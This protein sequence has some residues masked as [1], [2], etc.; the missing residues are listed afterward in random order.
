MYF[1]EKR[2]SDLGTGTK[3][4]LLFMFF[5]VAAGTIYSIQLTWRILSQEKLMMD[6]RVFDFVRATSGEGQEWFFQSISKLGSVVV[7][8]TASVLIL[9]YFLFLSSHS[10]WLGLYFALGMA[11]V[12]LITKLAKMST[13][14]DRPEFMGDYHGS[15]S[16]FPSGHTSGAV[17]FYGFMMYVIGASKL[18]R[19]WK[20][21]IHL[22][23]TFIIVGI[24]MSRV[25]LGV[26]Y[27]SDLVTGF[28][29]GC[30]WLALC[31]TGFEMT[32]RY[33]VKRKRAEEDEE[34]QALGN[35]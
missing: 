8:A 30:V 9:L 22:L 11:G 27:F 34:S 25:Y 10:K 31:I 18:G 14:R 16:S 15:T 1:S 32:M 24:S 26:H 13:S 17:V 12:S 33:R 20:A 21:A 19:K 35:L 23:L 2:F 28:F 4:L 5:L 6:Q 7:L 3:A 29:L